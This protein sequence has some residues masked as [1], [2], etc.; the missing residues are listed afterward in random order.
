MKW[1]RQLGEKFLELLPDAKA[2]ACDE[3]GRGYW[4][5]HT[6]SE[7]GCMWN[8]KSKHYLGHFQCDNWKESLVVKK[9][10]PKKGDRYYVPSPE[11]GSLWFSAFWY[12]DY[13][14][15]E[16]FKNNL[17]CKTKEEAIEKAKK[18]LEAVK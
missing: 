13:L 10:V 15:R 4:Y 8:E 5:K 14:N 9:W 18:M 1:T 2:V 16:R 7:G 17:V 11:Y 6:P 3:G 12:E